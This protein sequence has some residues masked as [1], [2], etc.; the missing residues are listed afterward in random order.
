MEKINKSTKSTALL[1][2]ND[3]N[4]YR[5]SNQKIKEEDK[6]QV[7]EEAITKYNKSVTDAQTAPIPNITLHFNEVLC[8]AVPIEVRSRAGL[9]IPTDSYDAKIAQKVEYM[10]DAVNDEQEILMIGNMLE[11]SNY[12]KIQPGQI[13]KINFKRFRELED[14]GTGIIKTKYDIPCYTIN[15]YKYIIIDQRDIIYTFNNY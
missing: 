9:I 11:T 5:K 13:A 3:L 6:S 12:N 2:Y 10:S 1:H 8:R 7:I 4:K 14:G 15:G